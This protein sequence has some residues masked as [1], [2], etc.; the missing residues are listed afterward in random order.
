VTAVVRGRSAGGAPSEESL[1]AFVKDRLAG[2]K[3]PKRVVMTGDNLRL[4][5]GKPHYK[6]A[7]QITEHALGDA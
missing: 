5:N 6:K 3:A 2:Y 7:K 4:P 1:Q